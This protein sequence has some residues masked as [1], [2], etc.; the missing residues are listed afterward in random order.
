[1]VGKVELKKMYHKKAGDTEKG[2]AKKAAP[3]VTGV[4]LK[5]LKVLQTM[6]KG[7]TGSVITD[8]LNEWLY[9]VKPRLTELADQGYIQDSG[10]REKNERNRNEIVWIITTKGRNYLDV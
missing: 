2:A 4:R 3:R 7:A 5:A 9:T 1:M 8:I 10:V 6:P